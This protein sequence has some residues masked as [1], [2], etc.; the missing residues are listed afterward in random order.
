[1]RSVS[2]LREPPLRRRTRGRALLALALLVVALSALGAPEPAVAYSCSAGG[3]RTP[4]NRIEDCRRPVAADKH[5]GRPSAHE[6]GRIGVTPLVLL[7]LALG[8]TLLV[9]IGFDRVTRSEDDLHA[10]RLL[11]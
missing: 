11:R 6:T 1:M 9:P 10:D 5:R 3:S 8:G 2:S 4:E 7:V